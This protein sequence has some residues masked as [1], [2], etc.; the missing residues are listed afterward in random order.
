MIKHPIVDIPMI[1]PI[2]ISASPVNSG[3]LNPL[4]KLPARIA[5][6]RDNVRV[7]R[8]SLCG[9]LRQLGEKLYASPV[10]FIEEL[11]QNADDCSHLK[12]DV[13]HLVM[14][15]SSPWKIPTINGGFKRWENHLFRLGP[16]IPWLS[17]AMLVITRGYIMGI[18]PNPK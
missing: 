14:T 7:L 12:P 3:C 17:M 9:G 11:L 5:T 13:D 1:Y 8:S 18:S 4:K 6:R 15:N 10:H 16:S 2:P